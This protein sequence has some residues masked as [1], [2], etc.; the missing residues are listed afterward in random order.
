MEAIGSSKNAPVLIRAYKKEAELEIWKMKADGRYAYLK[1]LPDVPL[2][3]AAR[4]QGPRGRPPGAGRLLFD[5]AGAHEPE[6]RLLSLV[7]RRLS[8]YL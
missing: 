1:I 4:A 6:F 3:G 2:V 7:R 5:Y 8:Q